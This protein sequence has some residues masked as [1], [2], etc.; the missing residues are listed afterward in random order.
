[1]TKKGLYSF[2]KTCVNNYFDSNYHLV[3]SPSM[4]L[5]LKDLPKD[6]FEILIK[7]TYAEGN[8]NITSNIDVSKIL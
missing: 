1:M 5:T 7:A 8:L 6:I 3:A 2:D 4:P